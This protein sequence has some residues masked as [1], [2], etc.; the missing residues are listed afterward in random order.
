MSK[1]ATCNLCCVP[2]IAIVFWRFATTVYTA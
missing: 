2:A 1:N